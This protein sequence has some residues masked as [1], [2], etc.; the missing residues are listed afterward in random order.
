[1]ERND[2]NSTRTFGSSC[3]STHLRTLLCASTFKNTTMSHSNWICATIQLVSKPVSPTNSKREEK[4]EYVLL[5][6]QP[7]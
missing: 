5:T 4:K 2:S 7:H 3:A 6:A 1:M